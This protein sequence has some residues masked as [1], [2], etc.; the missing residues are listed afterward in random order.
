MSELVSENTSDSGYVISD[1]YPLGVLLER[2]LEEQIT[3]SISKLPKECRVVFQKSRFEEKRYEE[4]ACEL[5]ISV[6]TVKYH[7]KRALSLLKLDLGKYL[8]GVLLVFLRMR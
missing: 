6:N 4:I 2:E 5:G 3:A 8:L 7:I 1:T